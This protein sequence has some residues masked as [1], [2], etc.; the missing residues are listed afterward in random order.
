MKIALNASAKR[1]LNLKKATRRICAQQKTKT[2]SKR[3]SIVRIMEYL[4]MKN[5]SSVCASLQAVAVFLT[6]KVNAVKTFKRIIQ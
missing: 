6:L 3:S 2:K 5:Y 4:K 1:D